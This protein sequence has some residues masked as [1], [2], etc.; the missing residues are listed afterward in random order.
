MSRIKPNGQPA[1]PR[2]STGAIAASH[3]INAGAPPSRSRTITFSFRYWGQCRY[4]GLEGAPA[5]W[6]IEL[7][8]RLGDLAQYEIDAFDRDP[9]LRDSYRYHAVNWDQP[10]IPIA[11]SDL[12]WVPDVYRD[13]TD[14]YPFY[15][16]HV[17]KG[18][19]RF[20][21]FWDEHEVFNVVL[22]DPHHNLQPIK[23][24]RYETTDCRSLK[25]REEA[26]GAKLE[27]L[28]RLV[29][30]AAITDEIRAKA[31][32]IIRGSPRDFLLFYIDHGLFDK[33]QAIGESELAYSPSQVLEE[34]IS[35]VFSTLASAAGNT[36]TAAPPSI[37][38]DSITKG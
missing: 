16:F 19:G 18:A 28:E 10:G 17:S 8:N 33:L 36:S 27:A 38:P 34:G 22:L 21:G 20:A 25:I 1:K 35:V 26:L 5:N 6:L 30:E 9:V 3:K 7:L 2:I 12:T 15:Q 24:L 31:L 4:F 23:K 29:L 37:S 32:K 13:N 11:R 14:D